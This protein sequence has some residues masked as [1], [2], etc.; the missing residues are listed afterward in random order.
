MNRPLSVAMVFGDFYFFAYHSSSGHM[1]GEVRTEEVMR[2]AGGMRIEQAIRTFLS[3][4]NDNPYHQGSM[5]MLLKSVL[6]GAA[7]C[8]AFGAVTIGFSGPAAALPPIEAC[9]D[10][11]TRCANGDQSACNSSLYSICMRYYGPL[12]PLYSGVSDPSR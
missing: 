7:L 2:K 12:I 3:V 5:K 1:G 8:A 6:S 4:R 10:V 9:V 11:Q